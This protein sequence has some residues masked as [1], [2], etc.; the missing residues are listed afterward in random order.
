MKTHCW[1]PEDLIA[2]ILGLG[3]VGLALLSAWNYD[4]L[5]WSAGVKVWVDPIKI[6][7]PIGSTWAMGQW[8]SLSLT[9]VAWT[10][11]AALALRLTRGKIG[12]TNL[13]VLGSLL[14]IVLICWILGHEG[15][16]AHWPWG[17]LWEMYSRDLFDALTTSF[18]RTFGSNPPS[19]LWEGR[20]E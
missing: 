4:L 19:C 16:L 1:K 12:V 9:W 7:T 13:F 2:L 3:I 6:V 8:V 10:A 11:V 18:G 5:G 15:H 20:W 17:F 14:A